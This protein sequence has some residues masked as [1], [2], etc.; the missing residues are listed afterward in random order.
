MDMTDTD[1]KPAMPLF[2]A[3]PE[4]LSAERHGD[5]ALI[6]G[7]DYGFAATANAIPL[8]AGEMAQAMRSYPIVFAGQQRMPV[9]LTGIKQGENLYVGKDGHWQAGHYVPAYVRRHPFVLAGDDTAKRLTLCLDMKAKSV[10]KIGTKGANPLFEDGTPTEL[11]RNAI[12]FCEEF[13]TM[14]NATKAVVEQIA[15]HGLLVE[16]TSR[17]TLPDGK[18]HDVNGFF[19][20]DEAKLGALPDDAFLELRKSGALTAIYCHLCS[21]HSWQ[22]LINQRGLS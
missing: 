3:A 7:A 13:Q 19:G 1:T 12:A 18:A 14:Y 20:I 6:P 9:A 17:I 10:A 5:L 16:Q 8:M 2:Y 21:A 4:A 15:R 11:V 22:S